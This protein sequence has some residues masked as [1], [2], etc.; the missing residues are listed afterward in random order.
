MFCRS[1]PRPAAGGERGTVRTHEGS[2]QRSR[3]EASSAPSGRCA[4]D[5]GLWRQRST[6]IVHICRSQHHERKSLLVMSCSHC[7]TLHITRCG[8]TIVFNCVNHR[9]NSYVNSQIRNVAEKA[10]TQFRART[11]WYFC[12]FSNIIF[13]LI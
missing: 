5:G 2:T 8:K 4:V 1:Q 3:T 7:I 6:R 9:K 12:L 13:I 11:L 10:S